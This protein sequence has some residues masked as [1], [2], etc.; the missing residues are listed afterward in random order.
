MQTEGL[1]SL[2]MKY[3]RKTIVASF[4]DT[5]TSNNTEQEEK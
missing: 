5:G 1:W 2:Q 4:G 3:A